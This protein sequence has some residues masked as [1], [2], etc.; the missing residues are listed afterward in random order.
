M[1]VAG[2][3]RGVH[4]GFRC[5]LGGHQRVSVIFQGNSRVL[6]RVSGAFQRVSGGSSESQVRRFRGSQV[7][8][9]G[10]QRISKGVPGGFKGVSVGNR[11]FQRGTWR[12]DERFRGSYGV[13]GGLGVHQEVYVATSSKALEPS[14]MPHEA[15]QNPLLLGSQRI[16][17]KRP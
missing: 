15:P 6:Q 7:C 14:E 16:S 10:S 4:G 2:G 5:V 17:W 1:G 8:F 12:S 9:R 11:C 13:S 3:F